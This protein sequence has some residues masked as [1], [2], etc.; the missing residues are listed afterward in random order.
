LYASSA[1]SFHPLRFKRARLVE[2]DLQAD[3]VL[4][5]DA[6]GHVHDLVPSL[7][8]HEEVTEAHDEKR[9]RADV[10]QLLQKPDRIVQPPALLKRSVIDQAALSMFEHVA[11]DAEQTRAHVT[12]QPD[13][14]MTETSALA[15]Q[16]ANEAAELAA[17]EDW[18]DRDNPGWRAA[19]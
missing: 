14:Q 3:I 2:P 19:R 5:R 16:A 4:V 11:L 12:T 17:Q 9:V 8:L 18:L 1:V 6:R 7:L 15:A 13:A 10:D